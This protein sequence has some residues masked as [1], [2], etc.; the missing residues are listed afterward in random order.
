MAAFMSHLETSRAE[1]QG[2]TRARVY[3]KGSATSG[4]LR[5]DYENVSDVE[6]TPYTRIH[7]RFVAG[8]LSASEY[9]TDLKEA[10]GELHIVN[11][12]RYLSRRFVPPV[13]GP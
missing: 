10:D 9:E 13:I 6:M 1:L 8:D 12:G 3:Q 2:P 4:L 11:R 7:S 5:F